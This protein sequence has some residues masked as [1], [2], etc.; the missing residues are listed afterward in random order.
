[1]RTGQSISTA[2]SSI[3]D[4]ME[5]TVTSRMY[6]DLACMDIWDIFQ[7]ELVNLILPPLAFKEQILLLLFLSFRRPIEGLSW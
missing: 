7:L 2:D 3:V 6:R 1:M 5:S 4:I